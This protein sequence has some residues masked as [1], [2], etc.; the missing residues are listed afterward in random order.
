MR[1][2]GH[3]E[4]QI[5][6]VFVLV[7]QYGF[8]PLEIGASVPRQFLVRRRRTLGTDRRHGVGDFDTTPRRRGDRGHVTQRAERRRRVWNPVIGLDGVRRSG[9]D[10]AQNAVS[11]LDR[12]GAV[13]LRA[14]QG[15]GARQT[16]LGAEKCQQK[17]AFG[18]GAVERGTSLRNL[19]TRDILRALSS[20]VSSLV[21]ASVAFVSRSALPL[22]ASFT[23]SPIRLKRLWLPRNLTIRR[24]TISSSVKNVASRSTRCDN[25]GESRRTLLST[26]MS[27]WR[28]PVVGEEDGI[29]RR[30]VFPLPLPRQRGGGRPHRVTPPRTARPCGPRICGALLPMDDPLLLPPPLPLSI[31]AFLSRSPPLRPSFALPSP[32]PL[33]CVRSPAPFSSPA[34]PPP[35][36]SRRR[37]PPTSTASGTACRHLQSRALRAALAPRSPSRIQNS[38][39]VLLSRCCCCC[40]YAPSGLL[41]P[42]SGACVARADAELPSWRLIVVTARHARIHDALV[43]IDELGSSTVNDPDGIIGARGTMVRCTTLSESPAESPNSQRQRPRRTVLRLVCERG[44]IRGGIIFRFSIRFSRLTSVSLGFSALQSPQHAATC[45]NNT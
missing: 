23:G 30:E 36:L 2:F 45:C 3:V 7:R 16:T 32:Q 19:L 27:N 22:P 43:T 25:R 40:W 38:D 10:A 28:P 24:R 12:P 9:L 20:L 41:L 11:R 17:D 33:F 37:C 44:F 1:R 13:L 39:S 18:D 8:Q 21:V 6:A 42:F 34:P 35:P 15:L 4:V 31:S 14:G 29:E 5:Q 26:G